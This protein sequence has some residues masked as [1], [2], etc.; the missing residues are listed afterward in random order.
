MAGSRRGSTFAFIDDGG[1]RVVRTF[2]EVP[3]VAFR[4]TGPAVRSPRGEVTM[5][6]SEAGHLVLAGAE[7]KA[8]LKSRAGATELALADIARIDPEDGGD[9]QIVTLTD[10]RVITG[11]FQSGT[12]AVQLAATGTPLHIDLRRVS[13]ATVEVLRIVRGLNLFRALE[14]A[15]AQ[16]LRIAKALERGELKDSQKNITALLGQRNMS[17]T[18]KEQ[19]RLLDGVCA[20][21][22]GDGNA[23]KKIRKCKRARNEKIAAYARACYAVLKSYGKEHEGKPLSDPAV[24]ADAGAAL[25]RELIGQAREVLK[26]RGLAM[27]RKGEYFRLM[28][29]IKKQEESLEIAGVFAGPRADDELIRLWNYAAESCLSEYR[30]LV[31]VREDTAQGR[32]RVPRVVYRELVELDK[33]R[34]EVVST[35]WN[36]LVKLASRGFHIEDPDVEGFREDGD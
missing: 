16:V 33:K 22:A 25:A 36:F 7:G 17:R 31:K 10:G 6:E 1:S 24:F 20:L 35:W 21:R 13:R 3:V 9:R 32:Q 34:S 19:L 12:Y 11:R 8:V 23:V 29:Q 4:T 18:R 26:D 15:D 14:S 5:F 2:D 27:G 28:N 30:R